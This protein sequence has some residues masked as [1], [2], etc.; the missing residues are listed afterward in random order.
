MRL[1]TMKLSK[2]S[3]LHYT[4]LVYR[5]LLFLLVFYF[6]IIHQLNADSDL[7]GI[8]IY[9][10]VVVWLVY[11][12]EMILRFF[13]SKLESMGCQKQ[14]LKNYIPN[15]KEFDQKEHD[16]QVKTTI[17][18]AVVWI[19][20]N[21]LIG[22]LYFLG[23]YG[24]EVLFLISLAFGACDMICILFFCPFHTLI[25]KNKCCVS[26]RIYNWDYAMMFTPLFFIP[27][28]F[29]WSLLALGIALLVKWEI[30]AYRH[31]ERFL[32][33][34]N[35]N[36]SCANCQEKLCHHK[37]SLQKFLKNQKRLIIDDRLRK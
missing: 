18:V 9:M 31:P 10:I 33:N 35:K 6:Y 24:R 15:N 5:S 34:N 3:T 8:P 4:K 27:H 2:T 11:I 36:L 30:T 20:F 16:H 29:T 32:E 22:L 28:F 25:M 19:L 1:I 14:F 13:P 23:L 26:C 12:V 17:I 21:A 37:K 7:F